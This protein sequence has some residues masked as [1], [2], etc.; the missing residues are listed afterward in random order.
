MDDTDGIIFKK[1]N[2]HWLVCL[3]DHNPKILVQYTKDHFR[4]KR[5][6]AGEINSGLAPAH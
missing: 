5:L 3:S 2:A 1:R 6:L 4:T